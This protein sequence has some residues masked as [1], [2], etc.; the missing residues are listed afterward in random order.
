M[1]FEDLTNYYS[2]SRASTI[3]Y[4]IANNQLKETYYVKKKTLVITYIIDL[5]QKIIY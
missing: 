5:L 1:F 4:Y 2:D 3:A